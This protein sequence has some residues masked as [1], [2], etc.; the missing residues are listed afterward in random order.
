MQ[1]IIF[2]D[3][4]CSLCNR[5]VDFVYK[6]DKKNTFKFA[7][8]QSAAAKKVLKNEDL[9]LDTLVYFEDNQT[10]KKS[11]AALKIMFQFGGLWTILAI[12][13]SIVPLIIRDY[14]YTKIAQNRYSIWGQ[15][16]T[17]RMPTEEEKNRFLD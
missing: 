9:G 4:I 14:I 5:F 17:C 7:A 12:L 8:L 16:D 2:F 15:L 3:G 6:R 10:Y 13:L 11:T 1:R